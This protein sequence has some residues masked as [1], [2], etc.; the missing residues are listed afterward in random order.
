MKLLRAKCP[1]H[2]VLVLCTLP[3]FWVKQNFHLVSVWTTLSTDVIFHNTLKINSCSCCLYLKIYIFG[4]HCAAV[5][6]THNLPWSYWYKKTTTHT[7]ITNQVYCKQT[8]ALIG[9]TV[10]PPPHRL[11]QFL[12]AELTFHQ[13]CEPLAL[14]VSPSHWPLPQTQ[15]PTQLFTF[16]YDSIIWK[17]NI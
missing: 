11:L 4:Q 17:I 8:T 16:T 5:P 2:G 13:W 1:G 10:T 14:H 12:K 6:S 15:R 7:P 3:A 9:Y